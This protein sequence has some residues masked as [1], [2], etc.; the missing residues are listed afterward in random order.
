MQRNPM[1]DAAKRF[2]LLEETP[3]TVLATSVIVASEMRFGALKKG[4]VNLQERVA[5][6]L[7][8]IR[9]MPLESGV[10]EFYARVRVELERKGTPIGGN[11]LLI[12]AQALALDAIL[13]TD[14]VREF[15]RVEGLRLENWLR[16]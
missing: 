12:A 6:L 7:S 1:G 3:G 10:D 8:R 14:N 5:E 13:V 11:D 15:S 16:S 2:R 4:S 9:I